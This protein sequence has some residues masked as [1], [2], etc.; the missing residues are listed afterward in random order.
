MSNDWNTVF[1]DSVMSM[2]STPAV[3][4]LAQL[5]PCDEGDQFKFGRTLG[6]LKPGVQRVAQ[7]LGRDVLELSNISDD[8]EDDEDEEDTA[9]SSQRAKK[10]AK[11]WSTP[12]NSE[13]QRVVSS[14]LE[15]R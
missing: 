13:W 3:K 10:S 8:D 7:F 5:N 12:S 14:S 6:I 15:K 2:L 4:M 11:K 1:S 9:P